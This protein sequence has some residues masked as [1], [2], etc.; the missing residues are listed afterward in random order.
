MSEFDDFISGA[1]DEAMGV[2]GETPFTIDGRTLAGDYSEFTGAK[3]LMADGGGFMG[4]YAATILATVGQFSG[5]AHPLEKSLDGKRVTA[6]GREM[7]IVSVSVDSASVTL[8]LANPDA[9]KK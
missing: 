6:K 4:D 1:M 8:R 5:F 3:D 2:I 9:G 7:R